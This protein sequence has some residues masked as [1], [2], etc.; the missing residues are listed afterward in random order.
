[1]PMASLPDRHEFH[2]LRRLLAY[3]LRYKKRIYIAICTSFLVSV[4]GVLNIAMLK[5]ILEVIFQQKTFTESGM[6]GL[7]GNE[8]NRDALDQMLKPLYE[9]VLKPLYD[10]FVLYAQDSPLQT[11]AVVCAVFIFIVVLQGVFRF[12]QEY[13]VYWL[14]NR[15]ILDVQRELFDRMSRFNAA[16]YTHHRVG[17][18][19]SYFTVDIRAIGTT[20]FRVFGQLLLDPLQLIAIIAFMLYL[21]WKLTL[22]YALIFPFLF[23]TIRHFARMNREAGRETQHIMSTMGAFLQEHFGLIRLV[24]GYGMQSFQQQKFYHETMSVFRS[25]M[26]MLKA[27]AV[28]S[29]INQFLGL[30]AFTCILLLGGYFI[31]PHSGNGEINQLEA[32]SFIVFLVSIG[33]IYQPIRRIERALQ[34]VQLGIASAERVF[35]VIDQD[36]ELPEA[37]HPILLKQFEQAIVFENVAFEYE[38]GRPVLHD[39]SFTAKKGEQIALVGPSGAGK[40]TIINLIPRFYDPVSGTIRI[41]GHDLK[42]LELASLRNLIS[43][44]PQDVA[45]F[46]DSVWVNLTCGNPVFTRED[47]IQAAMAAYAHDFIEALPQGYDTVLGERGTLLSGGQCQRI[48]IARAF[49]HNTPILL[50]D[51][52]T[53]ALDSESERHIK[54]SLELLLKGKTAFVIAHRLSTILQSDK[55]LV[56]DQGRIVDIGRHVD[57]LQRC[58]LYKRL[59]HL[60]F[61]DEQVLTSS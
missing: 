22:L 27:M 6:G 40:T 25:Y 31:L 38:P 48:A 33:V 11:L 41:D 42:E 2:T 15:I 21:Q 20:I 45:I 49:L 46:S 35:A 17:S 7:N 53:S 18:L 28:S 56:L 34:E 36:A 13:M 24:Q 23:I 29:P 12:L 58:E 3:A 54:K 9:Y 14:G 16:F 10:T 43:L 37:E 44:V 50:L 26:R 57:L 30:F 51:E 61:H 4:L 32:S 8:G 1:M 47:V 19:I 5:P 39:I 52:A 55:I 59:Y 60:Q